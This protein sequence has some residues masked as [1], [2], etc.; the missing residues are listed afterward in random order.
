MQLSIIT[1][2]YNAEKYLKECVQSVIAQT[3]GDWEL[4][5]VDDGST[6]GSGA[7]CDEFQ[8]QCPEKIKV[9]HHTNCGQI[10]SRVAG[11]RCASGEYYLFLDADDQFEQQALERIAKAVG[12]YS[13]DILIYNGYLTDGKDIKQKIWPDFCCG[14]TEFGKE[15]RSEILSEVIRSKRFNHI[16]LKAFKRS[17]IDTEIDF[18][19]FSYI[20][21]EEDLFMQLPYFDSA[22][23][24]LY[25]PDCLYLYRDTDGSITKQFREEQYRTTVQVNKALRFYAEKWNVEDGDELCRHRFLQDVIATIKQISVGKKE[26]SGREQLEYLRAIRNDVYFKKNSTRFWKNMTARQSMFLMLLMF[27]AYHILLWL[28]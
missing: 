5:L 7:I 23:R 22:D 27:R 3:Y 16:W 21:I 11:M 19:E 10:L 2:V 1:P 4:I 24:F 15:E 14:L 12:K 13:P 17:C 26:L 28:I 8:I 20:R 9:I 6:D 18:S 25:L